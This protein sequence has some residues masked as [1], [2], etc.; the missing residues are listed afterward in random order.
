MSIIIRLEARLRLDSLSSMLCVHVFGYNSA[1]SEPIWTKSGAL[2][3]HCL[4]LALTD[5]WRNLHSTESWRARRN[6]CQVSNALF[7]LF[8]VSHISRNLKTACWSVWRWIL[9]EQNIENL[10]VMGR[11]FKNAKKFEI[12]PR[13]ATSGCTCPCGPVSKTLGRHVR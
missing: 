9:L 3:V 1:E 10:H 6:F 11:F 12:F 2:W 4:G 5:F 8:P 13:L 7:Y